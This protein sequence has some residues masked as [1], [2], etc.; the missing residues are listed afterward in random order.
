MILIFIL[1]GLIS[2]ARGGPLSQRQCL[3]ALKDGHFV[4]EYDLDV[5]SLYGTAQIE[6]GCREVQNCREGPAY[7]IGESSCLIAMKRQFRCADKEATALPMVNEPNPRLYRGGTD[8]HSVVDTF[9]KVVEHETV[10]PEW[11]SLFNGLKD[12]IATY[13]A[14]EEKATQSERV[15]RLVDSILGSVTEQLDPKVTPNPQLDETQS[16]PPQLDETQSL[17]P[18][19][20]PQNNEAVEELLDSIIGSVTE[21]VSSYYGQDQNRDKGIS[22]PS[23]QN[24]TPQ[25]IERKRGSDRSIRREGR[26]PAIE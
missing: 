4:A 25:D 20:S 7:F 9:S 14:S 12:N 5:W 26:R 16:L 3:A 13:K 15:A 1:I 21:S 2:V 17:P 18:P 11:K 23:A 8:W 10:P 22:P 19:R 6:C 24:S